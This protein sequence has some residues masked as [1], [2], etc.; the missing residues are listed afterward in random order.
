MLHWITELCP[1]L[2]EHILTI[3]GLGSGIY[4]ENAQDLPPLLLC[5][6]NKVNPFTSLGPNYLTKG[7]KKASVSCPSLPG[8]II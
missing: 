7:Q 8:F 4:T 3:L 6:Y 2:P 1:G 5:L